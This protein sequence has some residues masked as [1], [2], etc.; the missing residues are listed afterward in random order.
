MNRQMHLRQSDLQV[1]F[2]IFAFLKQF[3]YAILG[4]LTTSLY[5]RRHTFVIEWK[6]WLMLAGFLILADGHF[7][8]LFNMCNQVQPGV[9]Q[10]CLGALVHTGELWWKNKN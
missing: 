8:D 5:Y 3:S 2:Y 6:G 10:L 4:Y 1:H 9:G 7:S